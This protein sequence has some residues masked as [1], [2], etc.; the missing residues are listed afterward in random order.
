M[1]ENT[2]DEQRFR[3]L[4]EEAWKWDEEELDYKDRLCN[5]ITPYIPILFRIKNML[6]E[7]L[8]L[9]DEVEGVFPKEDESYEDAY[10][11]KIDEVLAGRINPP[12]DYTTWLNRYVQRAKDIYGCEDVY[13]HSSPSSSRT[14]GR[15]RRR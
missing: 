9:K 8:G 15:R 7:Y 6:F 2:I 14:H 1:S 4:C 10:W 12:F 11:R 13:G 5:D 3:Q